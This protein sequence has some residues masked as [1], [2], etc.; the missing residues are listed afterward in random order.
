[1]CNAAKRF[2]IMSWLRD[3]IK[4]FQLLVG[5]L[6][7]KML[8]T[9]FFPFLFHSFWNVYM[10]L[11]SGLSGEIFMKI[12]LFHLLVCIVSRSA[13]FCLHVHILP[14]LVWNLSGCVKLRN[15]CQ[16]QDATVR[17]VI[18]CTSRLGVATVTY[19]NIWFVSFQSWDKK[20]T[21][22]KWVVNHW[23]IRWLQMIM[24]TR[25]I[26]HFCQQKYHSVPDLTMFNASVF[27][28]LWVT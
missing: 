26:N 27:P 20:T 6:C 24:Q 18:G 17:F 1:M 22:I 19:L 12:T 13:F 8:V 9:S 15:V 7:L 11:S 4:L 2:F 14:K 3:P 25:F 5:I 16:V 21:K 23:I 10:V 28:L